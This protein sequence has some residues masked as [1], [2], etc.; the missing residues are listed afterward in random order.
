LFLREP[1]RPLH[2]CSDRVSLALLNPITGLRATGVCQWFLV[3][4]TLL[5]RIAVEL[6]KSHL[7]FRPDL[8]VRVRFG[9]K[10]LAKIKM[11][12][13]YRDEYRCKALQSGQRGVQ[14]SLR[15]RDHNHQSD[16]TLPQ[17]WRVR[18]PRS[19]RLPRERIRLVPCRRLVHNGYV[20][21]LQQKQKAAK[22]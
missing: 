19:M 9:R 15:G 17:R 16:C 3:P 22:L 2:E 20:A 5:V 18:E 6:H 7:Y 13:P 11:L 10:R 12:F 8:Q 14:N 1:S 4:E 21:H